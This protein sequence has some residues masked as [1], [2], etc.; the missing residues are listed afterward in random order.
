LNRSYA[1]KHSYAEQAFFKFGISLP[2]FD[3]LINPKYAANVLCSIS[4]ARHTGSHSE[5]SGIESAF[6]VLVNSLL[7]YFLALCPFFFMPQLTVK[8]HKF[9]IH[10]VVLLNLN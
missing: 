5:N 9:L 10:P 8:N 7:H 2:P 4:I 6:S 1:T 3:S